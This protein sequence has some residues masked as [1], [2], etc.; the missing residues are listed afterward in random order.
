LIKI[1]FLFRESYLI[2]DENTT[3]ASK[4]RVPEV[5]AH[6]LAHMWFGDLVTM[7]WYN[8]SSLDSLI[9]YTNKTIQI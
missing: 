4:Q 5:I 6:E 1:I 8:I 9:Q 3:A 7:E 2:I